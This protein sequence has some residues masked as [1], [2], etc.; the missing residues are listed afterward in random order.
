MLTVQAGADDLATHPGAA[1]GNRNATLCRLIGA[2]LARNED[3][4]EILALAL[5]WGERC[6]PSL[7]EAEVVRTIES[8]A[9]KHQRTALFVRS[10]GD[11]NGEGEFETMLL[12][13]PPPWPTLGEAAYHGLAGKIIKTLEP[14]TE[15]D[16]AAL[17]LSFLVCF[18]NIV[19][20]KP[21]FYVE[22]DAHHS[23]LFVTLVGASGNGR[24]G[25]SLGRILQLFDTVDSE[26][27]KMPSHRVE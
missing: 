12:P 3:A 19:G 17:L 14:E 11:G 23:N 18:G 16:P 7:P 5:S 22:G 13:E 2:H 26:W 21:H 27:S 10:Q 24:K 20:R 15:A 8:L 1:E 4:T 6:S 9:A 25:T